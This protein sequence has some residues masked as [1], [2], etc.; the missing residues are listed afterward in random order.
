MSST[1]LT[2]IERLRMYTFLAE[3]LRTL[4]INKELTAMSQETPKMNTI[5]CNVAISFIIYHLTNILE[6][7]HKINM[8]K[9][10][11]KIVELQKYVI[12]I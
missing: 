3:Q 8:F 1:Q 6:N 12:N 10:T 11:V 2:V 7:I 5:E 9:K 4:K